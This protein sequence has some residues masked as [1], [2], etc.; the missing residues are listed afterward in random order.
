MMAWWCVGGRSGPHDERSCARA[1]VKGSLFRLVVRPYPL[2]P[3]RAYTVVVT[4]DV[5]R[6]FSTFAGFVFHKQMMMCAWWQGGRV[7]GWVDVKS[8]FSCCVLLV[9][10]VYLSVLVRGGWR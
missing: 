3:P 2:P 7:G 6:C 4:A 5:P 8:V 9:R 10:T 1:G